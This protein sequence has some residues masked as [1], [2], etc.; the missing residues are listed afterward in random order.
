MPSTVTQVGKAEPGRTL[1]EASTRTD[2]QKLHPDPSAK[3]Q[4]HGPN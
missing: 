2:L 3:I 1:L 4:P